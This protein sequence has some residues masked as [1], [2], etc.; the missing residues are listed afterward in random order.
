MPLQRARGIQL[1][2]VF[3]TAVLHR[4]SMQLVVF[5]SPLKGGEKSSQKYPQTTLWLPST[6]E[7][8][9]CPALLKKNKYIY[10]YEQNVIQ[11]SLLSI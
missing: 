9:I 5:F 1:Q 8:K 4:C 6:S 2:V 11:G 3:S 7:G 10:I